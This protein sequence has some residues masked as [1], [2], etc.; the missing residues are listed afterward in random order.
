MVALDKV[1]KSKKIEKQQFNYN[2]NFDKRPSWI[3]AQLDKNIVFI[4]I[5]VDGEAF[6]YRNIFGDYFLILEPNEN[7]IE[8]F[9]DSIAKEYDDLVPQNIEIGKFVVKKLKE[10]KIN[11]NSEILELCAGTGIVASE[12][13]K[14]GYKN[15]TLIDL[16]EEELKLAKKRIPS[17]ITK[18]ANVLEL[19][20][21]KKYKV[22][23]ESMGFDSFKGKELK[24]LLINIYNHLEENGIFVSVDRHIPKEFEQ[25]FSKIEKGN[26]SLNTPKGNFRYDYFIGK[27]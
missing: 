21:N 23:F 16:S 9:Y 25:Q 15:I 26:F 4:K 18:K 10:Y 6:W 22:V 14:S 1:Y 8:I 24:S 17:A 20:L 5:L 7:D 11:E 2:K 12:L 3:K 19:N 13:H 27:R